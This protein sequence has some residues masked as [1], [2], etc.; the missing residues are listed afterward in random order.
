MKRTKD[1]H[2]EL[3]EAWWD[4]YRHPIT[5]WITNSRKEQ[6]WLNSRKQKEAQKKK[7]GYIPLVHRLEP[8]K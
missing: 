7:R 4:S 3:A 5:G 6:L 8:L 1:L 2:M